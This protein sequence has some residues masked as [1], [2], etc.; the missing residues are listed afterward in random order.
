MPPPRAI[1]S[2]CVQMCAIDGASGFCL[3]CHRTLGEIARWTKLGEAERAAITAALPTRRGRI[4][5]E[6]LGLFGAP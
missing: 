6:K 5:P 4:A 2:P 1:A 3:G